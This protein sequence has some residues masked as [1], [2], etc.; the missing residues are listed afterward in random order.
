LRKKKE[1]KGLG[2]LFE[3]EKA[4]KLIAEVFC[5]K[6]IIHLVG[7]Q[8]KDPSFDLQLIISIMGKATDF[9]YVFEIVA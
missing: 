2:K 3:F 6:L 1:N 7:F 4:N 5:T 8:F 9:E